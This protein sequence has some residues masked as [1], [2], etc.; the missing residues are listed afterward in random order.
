MYTPARDGIEKAVKDSIHYAE[1]SPPPDLAK[2]V[3][4]F[5]ELKT[6]APLADDFYLHAI[7]D[8]CVDIM[9]NELNTNIAGVTAL[10]TRYETLNLGK[11]FHYVGIQFLPGV[12]R[13]GRDDIANEYVGSAYT[14]TLP[15]IAT[16]KKMAAYDFAGKQRVMAALVQEFIRRRVV[17]P[18]NTTAAILSNLSEIHSVADMARAANLS[19]RQLQRAIR[20]ATGFSPHDFLKILRL[21]LAFKHDY[22]TLYTDQSHFIRSFRTATGYTP[23]QFFSKFDV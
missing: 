7:P 8:A 10:R 16:N 18:N 2:L 9:F 4:C 15:L 23:A 17:A 20:Q 12:W 5:W 13:G 19:T 11:S 22:Q 14:G 6:N 3:D 21:Q 1:V